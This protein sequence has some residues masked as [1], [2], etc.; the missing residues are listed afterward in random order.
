MK[1]T[2]LR[3]KQRNPRPR[4]KRKANLNKAVAYA[5][6]GM[7]SLALLTSIVYIS[8]ILAFIGLGLTFWGALFLYIQPEEYTKKALLDATVIPSISTLN[9][10]VHELECK[11]Q[12][13]YLPPKYL[14]D[15]EASRVYISKQKEGKL[16]EPELTLEYE[17]QHFFQNPQGILLT[18]PGAQ[19]ARLFE[20]RLDTNF[21]KTDLKYIIKNMP[22]LVVENLEIAENIE[23]ETEKNKI[24]IKITNSIFEGAHKEN[25]LSHIY[26]YLDCLISSAI[27]CALTK[28][29]GK[30]VTIQNIQTSEDCRIIETTYRI[31]GKTET[32]TLLPRIKPEVISTKPIQQHIRKRLLPNLT[33][34]LLTAT[35]SLIL[36]WVCWLTLYDMSVWGKNIPLIFLGSRTG[37]FISLGI[38]MKVIYYFLIG[39]ALFIT[40]LLTYLKNRN[41]V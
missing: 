16:P 39:L 24:K 23:I 12:A 29:T 38:G 11:G 37:E 30:P 13:I 7:G 40:G 15:P 19:L 35:G 31:L 4:T 25:K 33:S 26:P 41:K 32:T 34:S 21:T 5:F 28:A 22:R 17:N 27:A 6:I 2:Q 8:S 18:P 1:T 36:A 9:Q 3:N 14:K 20:K 10:I